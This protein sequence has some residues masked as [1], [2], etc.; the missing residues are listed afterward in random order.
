[1]VNIRI[2]NEPLEVEDDI[3]IL[4]AAKIL[5]YKIPTLCYSR[6]LSAFG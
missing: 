1:M 3:T 5:G 4:D 6:N 2:N